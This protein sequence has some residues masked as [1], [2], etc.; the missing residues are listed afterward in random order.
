MD[1]F[2]M[3]RCEIDL[4]RF[5]QNIETV[6]ALAGDA[7]PMAV[8]KA[9]AYGHG[10]AVLMR[11][12]FSRGIRHF[13]VANLGE[14]MEL[15]RTFHRGNILVLGYTPPHLMHYAADYDVALTVF[16]IEQARA[17]HEQGAPVKIHIAL[18]T[19]MHRLGFDP[20]EQTVEEVA[21]IARMDNVTIEGVFTHFA[22]GSEA[23]DRRQVEVFR[24]ITSRIE[25]RG[26]ALGHKHV[27]DGIALT[28]YGSWGFDMVRPGALFYGY[29]P[30]VEPIMSIRSQV[31]HVHTVPAGEGVSY[32]LTDAVGYDRIVATLP[33]G[34]SDGV[35]M[36][37]SNGRGF[38]TVRG[39]RAP[40]V[41]LLC[42]DM[43][44]VDVT[45]I[46]G[47]R[48][49][50]PVTVFGDDVDELSFAEA[51]DKCGVNVNS[52]VSGIARRVPRVFL[53]HGEEV[54][55]QDYLF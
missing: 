22:K 46:P 33:Y 36:G 25:A 10:A 13:G 6:K 42:M 23:S 4:D 9:N 51:A 41:G 30:G 50:D 52:L 15:R 31:I 24:D 37:L 3:T 47:V 32:G 7:T 35:P 55:M 27:S 11:K 54:E 28:K 20:C 2:S 45:D 16:T 19:G 38:V 39:R 34:Y 53:E 44:M 40:Y 8:I 12:L 43:C 26:V 49:G 5:G 29:G 14:A 17:L 48:V 21:E 1:R 18:N